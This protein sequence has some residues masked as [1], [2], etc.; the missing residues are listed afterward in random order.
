MSDFQEPS[1]DRISSLAMELLH[2]HKPDGLGQALEAA[3][4]ESKQPEWQAANG[5]ALTPQEL[6]AWAH[7]WGIAALRSGDSL[8]ALKRFEKAYEQYSESQDI[9]YSLAQQCEQVGLVERAFELFDQQLFPEIPV[10][11]AQVQVHCAY[12]WDRHEQGRA[13]LRPILDA[14]LEMGDLDSHLMFMRGL[15]PLETIWGCAAAIAKLSGEWEELES[16]TQK[17]EAKNEEFQDGWLSERLNSLRDGTALELDSVMECDPS[18]NYPRLRKAIALARSDKELGQAQARLD[19]ILIG[20]QDP[21]WLH[22]VKRI[23]LAEVGQCF[24]DQEME[25]EHKQAF[26]EALPLL[27]EPNI[28]LEFHLLEYQERLKA[29]Y[30]EIRS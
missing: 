12:L 26:L 21:E 16:F 19:K 9:R 30:R 28:A 24:S 3:L 4:Q 25:S 1:V 18:D 5:G 10:H 8:E 2:R 29:E 27:L 14:Y 6:E 20:R 15:P 11:F 22:P 13:Y 7:A 23:A 17:L